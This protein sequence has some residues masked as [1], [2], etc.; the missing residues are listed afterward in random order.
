MIP[1]ENGA[2]LGLYEWLYSGDVKASKKFPMA[3]G[4]KWFNRTARIAQSGVSERRD[5]DSGLFVNVAGS[6]GSMP[7]MGIVR[8]SDTHKP[9]EVLLGGH[10]R[11]ELTFAETVLCRQ[12]SHDPQE[13]SFLELSL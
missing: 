13:L 9:R 6:T 2:L 1:S 5:R 7:H 3:I 11:R 4:S 10:G 8:V 12:K